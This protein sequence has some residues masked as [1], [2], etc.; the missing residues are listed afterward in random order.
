MS[1]RNWS[2]PECCDRIGYSDIGCGIGLAAGTSGATATR[3]LL[4]NAWGKD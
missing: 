2:C 3:A 4:S 1:G